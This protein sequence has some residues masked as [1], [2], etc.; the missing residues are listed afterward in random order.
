LREFALAEEP[1][2][3]SVQQTVIL[4]ATKLLGTGDDVLMF[5]RYR[6]DAD[7]FAH[8][9]AASANTPANVRFM[10]VCGEGLLQLGELV[11]ARQL[12]E[13]ALA[14]D[15]KTYGED[16]PGV[17]LRRN[18]LALVLKSLGE[19]AAARQLLE[20]ALASDLK[21]YGEDHPGVARRR[22]NLA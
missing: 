15:L 10:T 6:R 8:L 1:P 16:H 12:F 5:Q 7:S 18:N 21:T 14:S 20:R 2:S 13:Q 3:T 9:V 17:A 22:D 4:G 11:A 19:L